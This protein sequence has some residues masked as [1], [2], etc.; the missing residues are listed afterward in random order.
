MGED[1]HT[2]APAAYFKH[3]LRRGHFMIQRCS[4]T[5]NGVFYPRVISPYSGKSTLEWI[6]ASGTG[7]VYSTTV[8][9]RKPERGGNYNLALIDLDEGGRMMSRVED[10][11]PAE[12]RIGMRV[13]ADIVEQG[14]EPVVVFRQAVALSDND[15]RSNM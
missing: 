4:V 8:V 11:D 2:M 14:G 13:R 6:E 10:I 1:E 9:H 15:T 12:V 3:M 5:G 7:T